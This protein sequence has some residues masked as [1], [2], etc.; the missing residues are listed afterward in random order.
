MRS[1]KR[2]SEVAER[3]LHVEF[4]WTKFIPV[5]IVIAGLGQ[6]GIGISVAVENFPRP[7]S[8]QTQFLSELGQTRIPG[9]ISNETSCALFTGTIVLLGM[10]L[11]PMFLT[12]NDHTGDAA[13]LSRGLGVASAV[14]LIGIG[15]TP[16]D[17][18]EGLHLLCLGCWL[19]SLAG[20]ALMRIVDAF[21]TGLAAAWSGFISAGLLLAIA[22][23][24]M[25]FGSRSAAPFAQKIAIVAAI[26]WGL[27]L[28][29]EVSKYT[30]EI[31]ILRRTHHRAVE[32]YLARLNSRP[33]YRA[34]PPDYQRY[35]S[36]NK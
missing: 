15:V 8:F 16:F 20:M 13:L 33:L 36:S 6:F 32:D 19:L 35:R 2:Q 4:H 9:N 27:D 10:S 26:F 34:K 23:Y 24:A 25:S 30:M 18:V 3:L 5:L 29:R 1:S 22:A 31:I 14:A 11:I 17:R 21:E 28:I 7:F 12:V